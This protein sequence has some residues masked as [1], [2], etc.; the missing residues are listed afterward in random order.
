MR[1][2]Q[3]FSIFF[4]IYGHHHI[5]TYRIKYNKYIKN[6]NSKLVPFVVFNSVTHLFMFGTLIWA[7]IIINQT[8]AKQT[9]N[10]CIFNRKRF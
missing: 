1:I 2:F 3:I 6:N 7:D 8:K 5:H 10:M 4:S 9:S